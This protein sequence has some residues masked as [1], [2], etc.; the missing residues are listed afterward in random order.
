MM[1]ATV[2]G[3]MLSSVLYIS[4]GLVGFTIYRYDINDTLL[5]YLGDDL[6]K[7]LKTNKLIVALLIVFE[8]AFIVNTTILT[9]LN[10]FTGK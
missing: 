3:I 10:F 5:T 6:I 2:L 7:Y 8:I 1:K 9:M 4:F